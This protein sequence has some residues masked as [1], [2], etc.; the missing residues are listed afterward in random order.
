MACCSCG[1]RAG[2]RQAHVALA[3]VR[4][5]SRAPA[6]APRGR[7][8]SCR[9]RSPSCCAACARAV[10]PG[11]EGAVGQHRHRQAQ[12]FSAG[13]RKSR[14]ARN[15]LRRRSY[16]A[17]DSASKQASAA[18]CATVRGAD[19][20]VLRQLLDRRHQRLGQ[21]Q[22]AQAPAGHAEVL[23]EAV[24]ARSRRRRCA[25]RAVA[26]AL[27]VAQAQV[28][29]VDQRE[30][31]AR[32]HGARRCGPSRRGSIE[33]PVGLDGEASS[34]PRVRGVQ[35]ASTPRRRR[36]GSA[37]SGGAGSS[38]GTPSAAATKWRLQG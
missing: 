32:A 10:G 35:A 4:G 27:V 3:A 18:C 29:L 38:T 17:I 25:Q 36:A 15:S 8:A 5:R 12:A 16:S 19:V 31:A 7:A 13:T 1:H 28:D 21:H 20:E 24:D 11:V 2:V 26:E 22:P 34:T 30:A 6:S 9:S 33:V 37:A 14:R 23:G